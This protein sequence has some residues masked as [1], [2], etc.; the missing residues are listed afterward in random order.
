M[1]KDTQKDKEYLEHLNDS[2]IVNAE[3]EN[4]LKKA[5]IS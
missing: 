4:E 1:S 5:F 2:K 3:V